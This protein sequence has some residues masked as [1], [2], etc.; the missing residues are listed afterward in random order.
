MSV[1][2]PPLATTIVL[3]LATSRVTTS[4][5][6]AREEAIS[7]SDWMRDA[8][9]FSGMARATATNSSGPISSMRA[10]MR[11]LVLSSSG[12]TLSGRIVRR[13]MPGELGEGFL[14]GG[15]GATVARRG[16]FR[17]GDGVLRVEQLAG[18]VA[19]GPF[20]LTPQISLADCG[21]L[22]TLPLAQ[23]WSSFAGSPAA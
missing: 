20:L 8:S 13:T 6:P 21:P 5:A 9:P 3:I 14:I 22:V 10:R 18:W 16:V 17:A 23:S 15:R 7:V 19:P 12:C 11:K 2:R 1:T 4:R